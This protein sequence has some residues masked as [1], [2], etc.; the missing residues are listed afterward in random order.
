MNW[1][2]CNTR[3]SCEALKAS[4]YT[5][6]PTAIEEGEHKG[7]D[8]SQHRDPTQDA[9]ANVERLPTDAHALEDTT[10]QQQSRAA[11]A[12]VAGQSPT[13]MQPEEGAQPEGNVKRRKPRGPFAD[14]QPEASRSLAEAQPLGT[15]RGRHSSLPMDLGR[16]DLS[17]G[18]LSSVPA[19][20]QQPGA[21]RRSREF[22]ALQDAEIIEMCRKVS[23]KAVITMSL[24]R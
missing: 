4:M 7:E 23:S 14:A 18:R 5:G 16:L 15:Q 19:S 8:E 6:S 11:T 3:R 9:E 21:G 1:V 24:S 2:C 22:E 17:V 12:M 20:T 13:N 10:V